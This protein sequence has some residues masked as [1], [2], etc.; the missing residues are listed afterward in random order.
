MN[1]IVINSFRYMEKTYKTGDNFNLEVSDNDINELV[2]LEAIK[3]EA[4]SEAGVKDGNGQFSSETRRSSEAGV[5]PPC[6]KQEGETL[7]EKETSVYTFLTAQQQKTYVDNITNIEELEK[8]LP[9][10]KT[11]VQKYI[12]KKIREAGVKGGNEEFSTETARSSETGAY[13]QMVPPQGDPFCT[14]TEVFSKRRTSAG[15]TTN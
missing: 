2:D 10:S 5:K 14:K 12:N 8:L 1:Y 13:G 3:L 4:D 9:V 7:Q 11:I 15:S 6:N